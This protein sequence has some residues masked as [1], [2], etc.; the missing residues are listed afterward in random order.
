MH[1]TV[2][3]TSARPTRPRPTTTP[4][5][6]RARVLRQVR[7]Q[8]GEAQRRELAA[9]R[10]AAPSAAP[11]TDRRVATDRT[12]SFEMRQPLGPVQRQLRALVEAGEVL[13]HGTLYS[14]SDT[15]LERQ[16]G[17]TG[18]EFGVRARVLRALAKP[19]VQVGG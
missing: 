2:E 12:L 6:R 8:I 1:F 14:L 10:A 11:P 9:A 19:A 17:R 7:D 16:R 5:A 13:Q 3:T 18:P 15:A 4:D